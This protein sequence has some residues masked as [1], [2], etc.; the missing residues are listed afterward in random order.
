MYGQLRHCETPSTLI[1]AIAATAEA[2]ANLNYELDQ[3]YYDQV[4][5]LERE[6]AGP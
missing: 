6:Q 1:Q 5:R 3:I 2:T 4:F